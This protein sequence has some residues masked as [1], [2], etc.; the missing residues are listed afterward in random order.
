[1]SSD[2]PCKFYRSGKCKSGSACRFSHVSELSTRSSP[3]AIG[4]SASACKFF[5]KGGCKNG[6]SC[7]FA[8]VLSKRDEEAAD[9][10][11]TA[12]QTLGSTPMSWSSADIDSAFFA[13]PTAP[14][15]AP[16]LGVYTSSTVA[17][18]TE[19]GLGDDD[20]AV[21][22]LMPSSLDA[23]SAGTSPLLTGSP[24]P[25]PPAPISIPAGLTVVFRPGV[26]GPLHNSLDVP[27]V[28]PITI[29]DDDGYQPATATE[30]K[31]SYLSAA[32]T[33]VKSAPP[34]TAAVSAEAPEIANE[35]KM[36]CSFHIQGNCRYGSRCRYVHG[37]VCDTCHKPVLLP[38][39][40]LQNE[41]HR[42]TCSLL[43]D[44]EAID[45]ECG[46]CG[47]YVM[48]KPSKFGLLSG[49]DHPFCLDCIREW[50]SGLEVAHSTMRSCPVCRKSSHFVIPSD[51]LILDPRQ[52]TAVTEAYRLR[53]SSI[54]CKHYGYG[55]GKCPFG[56]SCFYMHAHKDGTRADSAEITRRYVGDD[57]GVR[58][59]SS[60]TLSDFF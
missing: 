47:Q 50:R 6:S 52:K 16:R 5:E 55:E 42:R 3:I 18:S 36:L 22:L 51:R 30:S 60:V 19:N 4:A 40:S 13:D 24:S 14:T 39:S 31:T 17:G 29:D 59:M 53:L 38:D 8:H 56:A 25:S 43:N 34:L 57:G 11:R 48:Q 27:S 9:R 28:G 46:I 21:Q 2:T 20:D 58:V 7:R 1:M 26:H 33:N 10:P 15:M 44:G 45:A 37:V 32:R 35:E 54:P 41:E 23:L 12:S 49:C